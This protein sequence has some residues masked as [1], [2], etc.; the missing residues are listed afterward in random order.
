MS[1]ESTPPESL[2][3]A[4]AKRELAR[5]AHEIDRH[6]RLY[7]VESAPA[8]SDAAYDALRRRNDAIEARFPDLKRADSPSRRVGAPPAASFTKVCHSRPMLSLANALDD[9]DLAEFLARVRR[10]LNPD[11]G[12]PVVL[13]GEP[14]IDGVSA[15]LHYHRGRLVLGA[16]RG[17]GETGEDVTANLRTLHDLPHALAGADVPARLEVRGEVY[18]GLADFAALNRE[19][20]DAGQ[21]PFVNPRN[22]ASGGLRQLD[23]A[24]TEKRRLCF[25]A[26]GWGET[27]EPLG[28]RQS[29]VVARLAGWGFALV[30]LA[31]RCA[32][33][34]DAGVLY[35]EI[36]DA[37]PSLDFEIDGVVFKVDRI[38]WQ[39]RL[40]AAGRAPRWAIAYKFPA[41]QTTTVLRRIAVQVGRTGA[42]TPVAE[43]EPVHVGGVTVSRATLH[44]E[45]EIERKDI[46]AGD[47]VVVQRAGDVIPQV[48]RVVPGKRP[49][50]S[51][52][53]AAPT[54]CP[55]CGS[56]AVRE[57]GEAVR[58]C[59]GGLVCPAQAV[60]RLRHFVARDAFDIEGL[61]AK[62][63]EAFWAEGRVRS[64]VDIF[65]LAEK[66]RSAHAP[67]AERDG[68]GETSAANLFRAIEARRRIPLDRFIHALG[69]RHVGQT[70]ARLL[71]RR[72]ETIDGWRAAM[73][74]AAA[75]ESDDPE[76]LTEIDGIGP[77]VAQAIVDFVAELRN[78]QILDELCERLDIEPVTAPAGDSPLA[79]KTIVFTGKLQK[80]TRLEAKAR[81]EA[82][83]AQAAGSVSSST[84]YV[85]AGEDAGSKRKRAQAL[86]IAVLDEDQWLA[87]AAGGAL[88]ATAADEDNDEASDA[89][90]DGG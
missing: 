79:G 20:S 1:D 51:S 37:R 85:V 78:S 24:L 50:A 87:V 49:A 54:E 17:D 22:A 38:N 66:D 44:N 71:A 34:D 55:E 56:R 26:H 23:P 62:Q 7:Y 32:V 58:R 19:R 43:L 63:I 36:Q 3:R 35:R 21:A 84:D 45:D 72:Y 86:G 15:T 89:A 60:E 53:F 73:D 83:G 27:S 6:D 67:L 39:E 33:L 4:A 74:A 8:L 88:P 40:G 59:T 9:E 76:A 10:F 18:M 12:E 41:E 69:I 77:V 42:L 14:K 5:L 81:A 90:A 80:M 30:P 52:P 31:R 28:A 2:T 70:T 46:R 29:D 48:V 64:P 82:L 65:D 61:G 13:Y 68:W 57:P 25:F 16:T 75:P 11:G 47:T